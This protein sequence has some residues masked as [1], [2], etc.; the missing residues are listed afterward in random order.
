MP[1]LEP[2]IGESVPVETTASEASPAASAVKSTIAESEASELLFE[3]VVEESTTG[4]AGAAKLPA[5]PALETPVATVR[6]PAVAP[7]WTSNQLIVAAAAVVAVLAILMTRPWRYFKNASPPAD[8]AT[9]SLHKPEAFPSPIHPVA[10]PANEAAAP[11][12]SPIVSAPKL[13][14]AAT[15]AALAPMRPAAV[16]SVAPLAKPIA[17]LPETAP[18]QPHAASSALALPQTMPSIKV[19]TIPAGKPAQKSETPEQFTRVRGEIL[20]ASIESELAQAGYASLGLSVNDEGDVFLAG[21]FLSQADEDRVLAMIRH[22]QHVRDIHFTG[23]VWQSE[24]ASAPSPEAPVE[25]APSAAQA[26]LAKPAAAMPE[27][28]PDEFPVTAAD[29]P[30]LETRRAASPTE[31]PAA[32]PTLGPR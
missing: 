3:P 22:I 15:V 31:K 18:K 10:K 17:M 30:T 13:P 8:L 16:P 14:A 24:Q 5:E 21:T 20:A 4:E 26:P 1:S 27:Q 9:Q 2:I 29:V 19:A 23:T 32:A 6:K 12:Q 7:P 11:A 28:A 25:N